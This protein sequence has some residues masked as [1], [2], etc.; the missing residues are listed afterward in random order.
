MKTPTKSEMR[1][2]IAELRSL[3]PKR[4]LTY[5]QSLHVA[6]LQAAR[7]RLWLN[8]SERPDVNLIWLIKQRYAPVN[9]VPSYKLGE[10]SGLT[11]DQVTGR[12]EMFI[13]DSEPSVRQRF[14]VGHEFKHL[15]DFDDAPLLHAQLG[16]GN[17]KVQHD[18]IEWIANEFAAHLLMS[19]MLVK[20]EWFRWQDVATV[21]N[22]FN[23]SSE[24]MD[25]R[26]TKLGLIGEPKP[27]PRVYFRRSGL[28]ACEP[29][30]VAA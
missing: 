19:T 5:G 9:F 2:L 7:L 13:N 29:M 4:P 28:T 26:L 22:I 12:L 17:K 21:A 16:V 20:R 25:K 27:E 6:R 24:A 14:S 1:T 15:L 10:E 11:T 18:M 3:A 30:P 8:A 23:V